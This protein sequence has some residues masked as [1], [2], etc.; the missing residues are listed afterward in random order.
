MITINLYDYKTLV[1]D[2]GIQKSLTWV[3]MGVT[4]SFLLCFM[5]WMFQNILIGGLA[6][7]LAEVEIEVAAATPDYNVVQKKKAQRKKYGEIIAGI[8]KLRSGQ[9][10]TT[11]FLEDVGRAVPEG[12]WLKSVEQMDMEEIMT[13]KVPFLFIDYDKKSRK[14]G[15]KGSGDK[16]IELKGVAPADQPIVHFLEQLRALPYID[17]VVLHESNRQWIE[18]TPVHEFAIYCH[19]LKTEPAV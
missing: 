14:K 8:D 6:S 7:D 18:N 3:A 15:G 9:A 2:V 11:E 17:A 1:R 12:V 16:F 19:F 4:V 10:H 5:I 13:N